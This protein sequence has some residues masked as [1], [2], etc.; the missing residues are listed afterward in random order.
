M[1]PK[2][3]G[4][5]KSARKSFMDMLKGRS[6]QTMKSKRTGKSKKPK[7]GDDAAANEAG[8]VRKA[9]KGKSGAKSKTPAKKGKSK[10]KKI[11]I[12]RTRTRTVERKVVK[13]KNRK[14]PEAESEA[15]VE[16]VELGTETGE[17]PVEDAVEGQARASGT[18]MQ[19]VVNAGGNRIVMGEAMEELEQRQKL[20]KGE[21]I[22]RLQTQEMLDKMDASDEVLKMKHKSFTNLGNRNLSFEG[23]QK[24]MMHNF[25]NPIS[26]QNLSQNS[27][28]RKAADAQST[29]KAQT[30]T[31]RENPDEGEEE[32]V[33]N[34]Y[35]RILAESMKKTHD[36][37][38]EDKAR[39]TT[40]EADKGEY[41]TKEDEAGHATGEQANHATNKSSQ[42]RM[43]LSKAE[44]SQLEKKLI[45]Q[46]NSE[47]QVPEGPTRPTTRKKTFSKDSYKKVNRSF[48][49]TIKSI[50]DGMDKTLN[51]IKN[52]ESSE[53][54]SN[55]S[56]RPLATF[57]ELQELS[58]R[59]RASTRVANEKTIKKKGPSKKEL[60]FAEMGVPL[61]TMMTAP[62]ARTRGDTLQTTSRVN[63]KMP[64]RSQAGQEI[65][66]R[67]S[68]RV[69]RG[70]HST[71]EDVLLETRSATGVPLNRPSQ[72]EKRVILSRQFRLSNNNGRMGAPRMTGSP[73]MNK[74]AGHPRIITKSVDNFPHDVRRPG[75]Y[76]QRWNPTM[77]RAHSPN[78]F[79]VK[80][81]L[82]EAETLSM[83]GN[84][85]YMQRR[86]ARP[87]SSNLG[88]PPGL[89]SSM[90]MSPPPFRAVGPRV[91]TFDNLP[92]YNPLL[93][94]PPETSFS[95]YS[96]NMPV[97]MSSNSFAHMRP[98]SAQFRQ[99]SPTYANPF[100]AR[101]VSRMSPRPALRNLSRED[102]E[103]RLIMFIKKVLV[104]SSK[105]ESIKKKIL[106]QNPNFS[107]VSMFREFSRDK[108]RINLE[109]FYQLF[110][111][112]GFHPPSISIYKIM[113][114]LS[115]YTLESLHGPAT[116]SPLTQDT[117]VHPLGHMPK[118][119][120]VTNEGRLAAIRGP[121]HGPNQ[122]FSMPNG[123]MGQ[124]LQGVSGQ[125]KSISLVEFRRLFESGTEFE[126]PKDV[127]HRV[128]EDLKIREIDF[129]LFRQIFMLVARMLEDF[130]KIIRTMQPYGSLELFTY[131]IEFNSPNS[132]PNNTIR[133]QDSID[134]AID[135]GKP[136][137]DGSIPNGPRLNAQTGSQTQELDFS[138]KGARPTKV[139]VEE[140][141]DEGSLD[142]EQRFGKR[143]AGPKHAKGSPVLTRAS[144]GRPD[145]GK[146]VGVDTLSEMLAFHNVQYI[147][148]DLRLVLEI[149]GSADDR[150]SLSQFDRFLASP[151]W[152]L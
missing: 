74:R 137:M 95:Q 23:G 90:R 51:I 146:T 50:Y 12:T 86:I 33:V 76:Y 78:H 1:K 81:S 87:M 114:Y 11:K 44:D 24:L 9:K 138:K 94:G 132:V 72:N 40:H 21:G 17:G 62:E 105:I 55:A 109:E 60:F 101:P 53:H 150:I 110:Q 34:Q 67:H 56:R 28:E 5:T 151:L 54:E 63:A 57:E 35:N 92:K 4:K 32:R 66:S 126:D 118:E 70:R 108:R 115:S 41:G 122:H 143:K 65:L 19:T 59:G 26:L 125:A 71:R 85:V 147:A 68:K 64:R 142:Q 119:Y 3:G 82:N 140:A 97:R 127:A 133:P 69:N 144:R 18:Q 124:S 77:R 123:G 29:S 111:A 91:Q 37:A 73:Q 20:V 93:S 25:N 84:I 83:P 2:K 16:R 107:S 48:K 106:R 45:T 103:N 139:D 47:V 61:E 128:G 102:M 7:S 27:I 89:G 6:S 49:Q 112:F 36:D 75:Q 46:E 130:S 39:E 10:K 22:M 14:K 80:Q 104:Y 15:Q 99:R 131:L 31:I 88:A 79:Q 121:G 145:E 120:I 141:D 98:V 129:H 152:N 58:E 96:N 52:E 117:L 38:A 8:S 42:K 149:L 148:T 136:H 135:F 43:T 100:N 116:D 134:K 30:E 113:I 13:R